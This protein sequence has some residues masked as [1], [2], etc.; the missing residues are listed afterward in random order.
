MSE[1]KYQLLLELKDSIVKMGN[2]IENVV[3]SQRDL[4]YILDP[5][6]S[7][8]DIRKMMAERAMGSK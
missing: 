1:D 5:A 6:N 2:A 4:S 8:A 7:L 3:Q